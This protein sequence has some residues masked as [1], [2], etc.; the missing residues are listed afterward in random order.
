MGTA[1][2][3]NQQFDLERSIFA[4]GHHLIC[5]VDEAGRGPLAGPVVAAAVM[6]PEGLEIEELDDSKMLTCI[7][8]ER[9]FERIVTLGLAVS[10]G[11]MDNDQVDKLNILRASLLAM[12]K[13]IGKL[14]TVPSI[15]VIDGNQ[16]IP[17]LR[18]PQFAVIDGDARCKSVAA[19]SVVAKV[20]RDRIMDKYQTMYPQYTFAEHKGY[21]T[22]AHFLELKEHGPCPIHRRTFRPVAE[23]LQPVLL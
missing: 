5:G 10:I 22:P 1:L 2:A 16:L 13:A 21:P 15:V 18:I 4:Q 17:K 11:I 23:L 12:R 3:N 14:P 20:T 19:A 6:M 7:Q 8:R 9:V